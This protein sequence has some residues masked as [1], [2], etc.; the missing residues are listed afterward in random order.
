MRYNTSMKN[1]LDLSSQTVGLISMGLEWSRITTVEPLSVH[2]LKVPEKYIATL[3]IPA[4]TGEQNF[5]LWKVVTTTQ[6]YY[7]VG[8]Y[9]TFFAK[10]QVN[11]PFEESD[12]FY[13][14]AEEIKAKLGLD[15]ARPYVSEHGFYLFS[16]Q[17]NEEEMSFFAYM[18]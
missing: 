7:L 16:T 4:A 12:N 1:T 15:Q 5:C 18:A 6:T 11:T 10:K 13:T 3:F 2:Q 14:F 9:I 8:T 17:V